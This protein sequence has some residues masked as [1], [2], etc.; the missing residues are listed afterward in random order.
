MKKVLAIL[1]LILM[2]TIVSGCGPK[3]ER[4]AYRQEQ[5]NQAIK[6][7]LDNI[8]RD[9]ELFWLTDEPMRLSRWDP[10]APHH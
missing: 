7:G 2:L 9:V 4:T 10:P 3:T 5:R 1:S 8:M 6:R